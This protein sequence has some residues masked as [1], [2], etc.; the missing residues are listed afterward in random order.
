MGEQNQ[1]DNQ[2]VMDVAT[3]DDFEHINLSS[4]LAMTNTLH[5][6]TLQNVFHGAAQTAKESGDTAAERA[7]IVLA[8][9]CSYHFN[10]NRTDAFSPQMIMEGRRSLVPS[11]YIGEQQYALAQVAEQIDHPLL[12]A[13]IADSCWYTNRKLHKMAEIAS[14]SYLDATNMFFSGG[15]LYQYE[16]DFEVPSKVIDLIERAFSI[17]ASAGKRKSIPEY[18]KE[19]FSKAY[20]IAK[21]KLNL[22]AFHRLSSLGQ[23]FELLEWRDIAED[24][25]SMAISAKEKQYPEAVKKIWLHAAYAYSK[26]GNKDASTQC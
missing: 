22:I 2:P 14:N 26:I 10:P 19:T 4:I 20:K 13:R 7:Y 9:I 11:D 8:V 25:E 15:L 1:T 18:A 6:H 23:S 17:Y 3:V 12:R 24:S 21:D 16:S 5:F